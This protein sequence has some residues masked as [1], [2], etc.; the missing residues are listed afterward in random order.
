MYL[1]VAGIVLGVLMGPAVLGRLAPTIYRD[2]FVGGAD[3]TQQ[4]AEKIAD[5]EQQIRTLQDIGTTP[6]AIVEQ[7]NL[8]DLQLV[9]LRAQR[10][11]AQRDHLAKLIGLTT[12]LMLAVIAIMMLEALV[13]PETKAGR[14]TT[15]PPALGRL[16]AARYALT[17][18]W[19]AVVIAQPALLARLPVAFAG[20]LIVVAVA[21]AL[22]PLGPR[23]APPG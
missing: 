1:L 20:L 5:A 23:S 10:E 9:K 2:A 7:S 8:R 17:A 6:A 19:L 4:I 21:V 15:V 14:P 12:A 3:L 13:S 22:V 11:Q 16:V 18:M